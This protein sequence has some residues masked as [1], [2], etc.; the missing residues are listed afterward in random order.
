MII[1]P[2]PPNNCRT[3]NYNFLGKSN[4]DFFYFSVGFTRSQ[5]FEPFEETYNF[6]KWISEANA[7]IIIKFA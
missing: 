4:I 3:C 1:N 6:E 7:Y 2:Y 5:M